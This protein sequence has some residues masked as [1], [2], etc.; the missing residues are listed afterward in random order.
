[1]LTVIDQSESRIEKFLTP[2]GEFKIRNFEIFENF[3]FR[4]KIRVPS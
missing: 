3:Y 4:K 1:M 2:K